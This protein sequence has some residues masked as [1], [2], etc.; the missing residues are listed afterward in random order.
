MARDCRPDVNNPKRVDTQ[1]LSS[2]IRSAVSCQ[3]IRYLVLECFKVSVVCI[4]FCLFRLFVKA[5]RIVA[6][7]VPLAGLCPQFVE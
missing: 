5:G 7:F 3:L 4:T 1:S 2:F 6:A